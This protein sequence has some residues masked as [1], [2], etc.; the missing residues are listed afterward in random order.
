MSTLAQVMRKELKKTAHTTS[1]REAA[2][3]MKDERLGS[4]LV[5]KDG[6]L[7]GIVTETDIVRR[8]AADGKDLTKLTVEQIMTSPIATIEVT[9]TVQDAHD[10]MGDLGV[11]HLGVSDRGK[12]VGLVSVRDL[13]IYFKR[14]S[15]PKITQD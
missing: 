5:E 6:A 13:L 2:R 4:L 7:V 9:R 12:L 1:V 8:G 15:E 14:V 3:R 10:M 11:R